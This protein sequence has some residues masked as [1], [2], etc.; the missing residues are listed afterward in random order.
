MFYLLNFENHQFITCNNASVAEAKIRGLLAAGCSK[1]SLEVINGFGDESRM[2]VDAF[3]SLCEEQGLV[4]NSVVDFL[5]EKEG[6]R[7]KVYYPMEDQIN[8]CYAYLGITKKDAHDMTEAELDEASIEL[9][10]H[11]EWVE[12]PECHQ[13]VPKHIETGILIFEEE[14]SISLWGRLGI[15]LNVTPEEL[16]VLKSNDY[17]KAEDLLVNLIH[18]DRCSMSGDTYFPEEANEKY[19]K[20]MEEELS[21]DLSER[22]LHD[23]YRHQNEKVIS[24]SLPALD[25]VI[26]NAAGKAKE[27]KGNAKETNL[28]R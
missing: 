1:D 6:A 22:P 8:D 26:S 23:G 18:S 7:K 12:H 15:S 21:F 11:F 2:L 17:R 5:L 16:A 27:S 9:S 20:D 4:D 14:P 13:L 10:K 24:Q 3:R 28:E 25:D 19:I